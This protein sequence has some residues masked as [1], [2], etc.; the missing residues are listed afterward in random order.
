MSSGAG[1]EQSLALAE[2]AILFTNWATLILV[3]D[4]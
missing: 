2:A 1:A 3:V 4:T